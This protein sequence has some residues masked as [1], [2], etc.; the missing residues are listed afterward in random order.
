MLKRYLENELIQKHT[1]IQKETLQRSAFKA[2]GSILG[3]SSHPDDQPRRKSRC[4]RMITFGREAAK[5]G[6]EREDQSHKTTAAKAA[7]TFFTLYSLAIDWRS[8]ISQPRTFI[9][10]MAI[11]RTLS[12]ISSLWPFAEYSMINPL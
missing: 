2:F 4:P 7:P 12:S 8:L 6:R 3:G 10:S 5:F 9:P 1:T 11:C